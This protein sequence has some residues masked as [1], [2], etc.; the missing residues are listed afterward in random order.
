VIQRAL[1]MLFVASSLTITLQAQWPTPHAGWKLVPGGEDLIDKGYWGS[2]QDWTTDPDG[3]TIFTSQGAMTAFSPT[4]FGSFDPVGPWLATTGDFGV[5][6]T[7]QT[8]P[9]DGG[10]VLLGGSLPTQNGNDCL[11]DSYI[12]FGVDQTGSYNF[13]EWSSCKTL[14]VSTLKGGPGVA[15]VGQVTIELLRQSGQF[16]LYFNGEEF[17]PI[18]DPGLFSTGYVFPGF[19]TLP[20]LSIKLSQFAFEVPASDTTSKIVEPVGL[21]PVT[22]A[23]PTPGSLAAITG[24]T[25]GV[26]VEAPQLAL[27][28]FNSFT[29]APNGKP[30][31]A[32]APKIIGQ[33]SNLNDYYVFSKQ[34]QP[35]QGDFD[36]DIGDAVAATAKATGRLPLYCHLLIGG[37]D[38]YEADWIIN[39]KF[40]AAQLTQIMQTEI[41]T[42]MTHYQGICGSYTVVNEGFDP[43]GNLRT[44]SIWAQTIGP[45]WLDMA[46]QTARK[47]DPTAKLYL[48][49]YGIE[50]AGAKATGFYNYVAG[51]IASGVPI[52]GVAWECHWMP[53][54]TADGISVPNLGQ[55]EANMAQLAAMGLLVR[56]TELDVSLQLPATA[57]ELALQATIF[58]TSVQACFESPNCVGINVYGADDAMSWINSTFPGEGAATLFDANFNPKPAYAAVMN[59]L[60]AASPAKPTIVKVDTASGGTAIGQNTFIEIKGYSLVPASTPAAGVIWSTAP[61]FAQGKMPTNLEGISVTVNGKPAFI[62]FYCSVATSPTCTMDQINVLTPL[63]NTTGPVPVIVTNGSTSTPAYTATM[64]ALDPTLLLVNPLG[65]I[66]AQH[67]DY[68]LVGSAALYPGYTTPAAPGET[69][70][71]YAIGFGLPTTALVNGSSTQSGSMPFVPACTV[72]GSSAHASIALVAPGLYQINLTIPSTALSGDKAVSCTYN[73]VSTPADAFITVQQ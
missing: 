46:F 64:Q 43:N 1:H 45:N 67:P 65:P 52:G 4:F 54:N 62:Y 16:T 8:G 50:N 42:V 10:V 31:L 33:F 24:R 23:G 39:G 12:Q 40:T 70:L 44:D 25:F 69:V 68:S 59:T 21:V 66:A 26:E 18:N 19:Q 35:T 38:T 36:F 3:S 17:G 14:V 73:G 55:M 63:D 7:M 6:V 20:G 49:D 71:I 15:P 47:A 61:S 72:S 28:L 53:E 48:T 32:L 29:G 22:H 13:A 56:E 34:M 2:V 37:D 9:T 11:G 5:T 51:M 60:S 58:S 27:G 57:S 41:Q 30:N